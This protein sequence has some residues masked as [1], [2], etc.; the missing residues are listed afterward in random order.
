MAVG[1]HAL[2]WQV[3]AFMGL[4][5]LYYFAALAWLPTLFRSRGVSAAGAGNLLALMNLGNAVTAMLIP[6]LAHRARD[7]RLLVAVTVLASAAGLPAPPRRGS[8][9][10]RAFRA[11]AAGPRR[12]AP[13]PAPGGG[14]GAAGVAL[15]AGGGFVW[16]AGWRPPPPRPPPPPPPAFPGPRP[17]PASP[18][19]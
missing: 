4:Q 14:W 8:A 15:R 10:P 3:A 1:R 13:R 7:Q 16:G 9:R 19:S 11:A 6:V 12:R 18:G 17:T 5:S 2:G